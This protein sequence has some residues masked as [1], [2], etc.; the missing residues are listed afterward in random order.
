MSE[1]KIPVNHIHHGNNIRRARSI[2][3]MSQESLGFLMGMSQQTISRY[4]STKT[5][6]EDKLDGFAK[7]LGVP[8]EFLKKLEDDSTTI[9]IENNNITN[10]NNDKVQTNII[11]SGQVEDNST[12]TFQPLD[13]ISE[14]YERL[15]QE[16][17][18]RIDCLTERLSA[19]EKKIDKKAD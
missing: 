16:Q 4:E 2:K 3:D 13:K 6:E 15:L 12:N 18:A 19:L 11:G 1:V 9:F 7:A 8:V 14:L 5:I 17:S 10:E